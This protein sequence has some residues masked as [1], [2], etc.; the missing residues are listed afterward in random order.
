M[1]RKGGR[2][3]TCILQGAV[4]TAETDT[5]LS[6]YG[7]GDFHRASLALRCVLHL[8]ALLPPMTTTAE[9]MN[10]RPQDAPAKPLE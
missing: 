1:D 5:F 8:H 6:Q 9:S 2:L 3:N 10:K 4:R 7:P